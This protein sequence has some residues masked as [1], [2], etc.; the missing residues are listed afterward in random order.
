MKIITSTIILF[1]YISVITDLTYKT[2]KHLVIKY[3]IFDKNYF[4]NF[5][6]SLPFISNN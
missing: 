6:A 5:I 1:I 3:S 2:R 4:I